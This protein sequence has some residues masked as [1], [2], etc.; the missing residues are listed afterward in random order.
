MTYQRMMLRLSA[1]LLNL[2]HDDIL[3]FLFCLGLERNPFHSLF[4]MRSFGP[5][6]CAIIHLRLAHPSRIEVLG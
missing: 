6:L 2:N 1:R 4:V 5:E 3:S